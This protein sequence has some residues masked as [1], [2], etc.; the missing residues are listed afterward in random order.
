M[1]LTSD[2]T[3]N[4]SKFDP[5]N[6]TEETKQLCDFLEKATDSVPRWYDAGAPRFR[7]M[8]ENGEIPG[9]KPGKQASQSPPVIHKVRND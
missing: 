9:L 1:P 6:V 4:A 5:N 7:E 3:V 8:M 2:I